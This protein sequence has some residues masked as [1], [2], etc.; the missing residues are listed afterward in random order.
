MNAMTEETNEPPSRWSW[1]D[2]WFEARWRA[3]LIVAGGERKSTCHRSI[4]WQNH[5]GLAV[6]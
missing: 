6:D 1:L 3:K 5:F 4:R 2:R